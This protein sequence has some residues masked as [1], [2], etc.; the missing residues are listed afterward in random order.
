MLEGLIVHYLNQYLGTYVHGID[1]SAIRL[2]LLG[3]D[4]EL[5]NLTIK[6]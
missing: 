6:T 4:L 1:T 2:K 5:K 3:G